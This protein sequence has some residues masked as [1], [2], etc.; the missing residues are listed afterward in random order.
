M[1]PHTKTAMVL[2]GALVYL[3]L[4]AG[5]THSPKLT[6][7]A[8]K[9]P[10]PIAG[11]FDRKAPEF[12]TLIAD[13]QLAADVARDYGLKLAFEGSAV[14]KFPVTI[15]PELLA[16][17]RCDNRIQFL[18]YSEYLKNVLADILARAP[19]TSLERTRER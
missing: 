16:K 14:L 12:W 17:M 11:H 19:N 6:V 8:C 10:V 5:C 15:D 4:C 1:E 2:A 9:N 13:R 3:S 7:P 18:N